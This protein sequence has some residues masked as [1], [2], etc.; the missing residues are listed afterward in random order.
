M[1]E[2][3]N[4]YGMRHTQEKYRIMSEVLKAADKGTP[5]LLMELTDI[6]YPGQRDKKLPWVRFQVLTLQKYGFLVYE[7]VP[8]KQRPY[9]VVPTLTGYQVFRS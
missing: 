3:R 2:E 1:K 4:P 5:I 6:L 7:P 9:Q 8:G